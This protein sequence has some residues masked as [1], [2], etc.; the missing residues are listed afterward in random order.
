MEIIY[1]FLGVITLMQFITL[2]I[3]IKPFI[4]NRFERMNDEKLYKEVVNFFCNS[5]NKISTSFLQKRFKI[6]YA[7]ASM[8]ME[9]LK[10]DELIS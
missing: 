1:L 9:K 5:D 8:I 2:A 7:R 4:N 6:G 10:E 3:L